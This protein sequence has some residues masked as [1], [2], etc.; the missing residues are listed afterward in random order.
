MIE[1][2]NKAFYYSVL[3]VV[4]KV[5]ADAFYFAAVPYF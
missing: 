2:K 1:N 3:V 5:F 4:E